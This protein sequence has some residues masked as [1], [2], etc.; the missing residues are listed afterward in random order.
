MHGILQARI[1]EQV[2]FP[3]SRRFSQPRDQTQVSHTAGRF[4]TSWAT[5]KAQ[6]HWS[7][8]SVPSPED[9]PNPGID[10]GSPALQADFFTNWAIQEKF[11]SILPWYFWSKYKFLHP[12]SKSQ[13]GLLSLEASLFEHQSIYMEGA[14]FVNGSTGGLANSSSFPIA[15]DIDRFNPGQVGT[16]VY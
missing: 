7:E 10:Q 15:C 3:F 16:A 2:A 9:R 12:I 13:T 4:F 5:R 14:V 1:L 11:T 6:E 8:L